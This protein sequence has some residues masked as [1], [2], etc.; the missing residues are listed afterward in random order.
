MKTI[1]TN[2]LIQDFDF[3]VNSIEEI[4][5]N[6]FS[7]CNESD[8]KDKCKE[9]RSKLTGSLTSFG[10]YKRIGVLI[11][12]IGDA[13]T[14]F[15]PLNLDKIVNDPKYLPILF[16]I[17]NNEV[18]IRKDLRDQSNI[19]EYSKIITINNLK[20][21]DILQNMKKY[22]GSEKDIFKDQLLKGLFYFYLLILYDMQDNFEIRYYSLSEN[23]IK[24]EIL[25]G[26]SFNEISERAIKNASNKQIKP[27][28]FTNQNKT[29]FLTI[30][31][32]DI[33]EHQKYFDFLDESFKKIKE[34]QIDNLIIDV[35][36]NTG[37]NSNNAHYL[38][39]CLTDKDIKAFNKSILKKSK[40][41]IESRQNSNS[42]ID[43]P[44]FKK[45]PYGGLFSREDD[46]EKN[47]VYSKSG[48][49][50]NVFI[51]SGNLSFST[52][53]CF[54]NIIR[55]YKIGLILGEEPGAYA[56]QCGN[57]IIIQLPKTKLQFA[58]SSEY[59]IRP[60][61]DL[62]I[63]EVIPDYIVSQTADDKINGVDTVMIFAKELCLN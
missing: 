29:G 38:A 11:N 48:F 27:Y 1:N 51:L 50:G 44:E 6:I 22:I 60:S 7:W 23:K 56:N 61:G 62:E 45:L 2:E 42:K 47:Y 34:F 63:D 8:W 30:N 58:V 4:H 40:Q 18:F 5:P 43:D 9:I 16:E 28:A 24:C 12:M 52:T 55:D 10:F 54:I 57:F 46:I 13:H 31:T 15:V 21:E 25:K 33:S 20:I 26:M 14:N 19:P 17:K 49:K 39:K 37:G 41:V 53:I 35:R 59:F 32:F 3:F 36:N